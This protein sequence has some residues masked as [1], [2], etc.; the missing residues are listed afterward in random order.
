MRGVQAMQPAD[1]ILK[2]YEWSKLPAGSIIVDVGGGIGSESLP[3]ARE[4]PDFNLVVQDR[5][6]VI[7]DAKALRAAARED[8]KL[9][10]VESLIPFACHDPDEGDDTSSIPGSVPHEAPAPLL[11]NFGAVNEMSYNIDILMF[12]NFNSQERTI[13]H[14][15][16]LLLS[17]GWRVKRVYRQDGD[18]TYLQSIEA[19]PVE[20]PK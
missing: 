5:Q 14:L 15:H 7:E 1:A 4:F 20:V 2:A 6:P 10:L 11:A 3:L 9:L 8:T 19:I 12:C 16:Q 18:S 17:T 13:R